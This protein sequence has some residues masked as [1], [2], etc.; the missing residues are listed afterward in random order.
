MWRPSDRFSGNLY[1]RQ[2][3]VEFYKFLRPE[4]KFQDYEEL[5]RQIRR[6][7]D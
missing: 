4:V 2:A 3:R 5:S 1:G 6:D 7:A